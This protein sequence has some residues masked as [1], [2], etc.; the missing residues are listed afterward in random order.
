MLFNEYGLWRWTGLNPLE[1]SSLELSTST[2]VS[3]LADPLKQGYWSLLRS[4]TEEDIFRELEMPF[5][6]PTKRNFAFI[7]QRTRSTSRRSKPKLR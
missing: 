5:V 1:A 2:P 4:A 3:T 6:D 7:S